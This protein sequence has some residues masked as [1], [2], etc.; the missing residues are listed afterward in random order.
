MGASPTQQARED[1]SRPRWFQRVLPV[2]GL[3][4]AV[5]ALAAL[6]VPS[7]R[8]QVA[9]STTRQPQPFVELSFAGPT[10]AD[11]CGRGE[12][13]RV[14]FALVSHLEE[15]RRL[16]Y[17]VVVDP[18]GA[19]ARTLKGSIP[20]GPGRSRVVRAPVSAPDGERYTV[21]VRLPARHQQIRAHCS[22]GRP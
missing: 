17:R 15:R 10:P 8:E 6:V 2:T 18:T 3:V 9:L 4:L 11:M 14:R 20:V 1:E 19:P 7:F 13:A 21:T 22:A 12:P 16:A 5:V